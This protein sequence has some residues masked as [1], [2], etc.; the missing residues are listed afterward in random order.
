MAEHGGQ[1]APSVTQGGCRLACSPPCALEQGVQSAHDPPWQHGRDRPGQLLRQARQGLALPVCFLS[2]GQRLVARR[3]GA[4]AQDRRFGKGPRERRVA[5][6][7]AGGA[8]TLPGRCLG[9]CDHAA[10]GHAI[11]DPWDAG[12]VLHRLQQHATQDRAETRDGL[13]PG[14]GVGLLLLGRLHHGPRQVPPPLVIS[15]EEGAVHRDAFWDRGIGT[16]LRDPRP[17]GRVRALGAELGPVVLAV[18][19]L[20]RRQQRSAFPPERSPAPEQIPGRPH[21]RGIARGV[22]QHTATPPDSHVLGSHGVVL[23]FAPVHSLPREGMPKHQ[24]PAFAGAQVGE[25]VPGKEACDTDDQVF[26]GG[27]NGFEKR[28]GASRHVPVHQ[29]LPILVQDAEGHGAGMQVDAAV[30]LVLLRL[31]SHEVSSLL[32]SESL[33]LSAYHGGMLGRGPQ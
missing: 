14:Q 17:S 29:D 18:G 1:A 19:L 3:M 12:E 26:P 13:E 24:R 33:P 21:V 2:A 16:P 5:A 32:L 28:C 20:D 23:G 31:E 22:G 8:R 7:R 25:P 11:L 27:R 10:R 9:A 15:V 4:E 6:L 30:Q